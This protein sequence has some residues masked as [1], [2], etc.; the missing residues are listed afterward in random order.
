MFLV[1]D[2]FGYSILK[3]I[4]YIIAGF[5]IYIGLIRIT[6]TFK[7][8]DLDLFLIFLSDRYFKIKRV[9]QKIIV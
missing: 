3:L 8:E 5:A 7:N 6:K 1:Q 9:I 2:Y 4:V